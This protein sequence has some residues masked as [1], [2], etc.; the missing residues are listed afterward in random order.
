MK[1]PRPTAL[2]L[3]IAVTAVLGG[4]ILRGNPPTQT[5]AADPEFSISGLPTD[6][7]PE[8]YMGSFL[9]TSLPAM[10]VRLGVTAHIEDKVFAFPDPALGVGSTIFVFRAQEVTLTDAKKTRTIRTWAKTVG[11]LATEQNLELAD[12]DKTVPALED[13]IPLQ[14]DP[15]KVVVTR[16]AETTLSVTSSI[17]FTTQYKDDPNMDQGKTATDQVGKNGSLKKTY[18]VRREDGVEVSRILQ[19]TEQTADPVTQIVR[20]GTRPVITVRCKYNDTVLAAAIKYGVDANSLCYRMMAESNG[21]PNSVN[22]SGPYT[23]LFQYAN[24]TWAKYSVSAGYGGAS[25]TDP[26]AQIYVTA[27]AWSHGHRSAWPIP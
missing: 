18:L 12:K 2:V 19:K 25:I 6:R 20:K 10:L 14:A 9:D 3:T 1:V 8:R 24:S 13:P 27:W 21:H 7:Q 16:V 11:E 15:V 23:G 5:H 17:P 26:E 22:P 4:V